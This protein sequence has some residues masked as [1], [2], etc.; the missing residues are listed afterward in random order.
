MQHETSTT[1]FDPFRLPPPRFNQTD[2][3]SSI[4][5]QPGWARSSLPPVIEALDRRFPTAATSNPPRSPNWLRRFTP[6]S[7][8][9]PADSRQLPTP[10]ADDMST[11][12]YA[13]SNTNGTNGYSQQN[14]S[15]AV[16]SQS[17]QPSSTS[18]TGAYPYAYSARANE[19]QNYQNA[20]PQTYNPYGERQPLAN[21]TNGTIENRRNEPVQE[22]QT[23]IHPKMQIPSSINNSKGSICELTAQLTCLFWFETV[24]T[25]FQAERYTPGAQ[26]QRLAPDAIPNPGFRKWVATILTTTQVTQNVI[27]LALLFIFRLKIQN[28]TVKGKAGS[29][30]RLLTVALMLGNKFLDDNTYTNKTWAEVSGISVGEIHVMEVEFLSNMRYNLLASAEQWTRWLAKVGKFTEF[31]EAAS[32]VPLAPSPTRNNYPATYLPSPVPVGLQSQPPML[33][34]AS[35]G[36]IDH[37]NFAT[38]Q[39]YTPTQL[40]PQGGIISRKRSFDDIRADSAPKRP[41]TATTRPVPTSLSSYPVM[42]TQNMPQGVPRLPVPSLSVPQSTTTSHS[43]FPQSLPPLPLANGRTINQMGANTPSWPPVMAAQAQMSLPPLSGPS[44]GYSLPVS[45]HGTPSRRNSPRSLALRSMNSSPIS[46]GFAHSG[47]DNNSPSIFLQQR[48]SPYKAI[49]PPSTLLHSQPTSNY[50]HFQ[51]PP[52]D[53]MHYQDIGRRNDYRTGIVPE[54][55][56]TGGMTQISHWQPVPASGYHRV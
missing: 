52:V 37:S 21:S 18:T 45:N 51:P 46:A 50:A 28:P 17:Y 7:Q 32:K 15:N 16:A 44:A 56:G 11:N 35:N 48:Q 34:S 22:R 41:A 5:S 55:R 14:N 26:V 38:Q 36:V 13:Q 40:F 6:T 10:P 12:R 33:P 2:T 3:P 19:S 54:Y 25:L 1:A 24:E 8:A 39:Q 23:A 53:H 27:L 42:Q 4:Y 31:F 43:S 29:E 9:R 20:L 47:Y 49:L 30:Y